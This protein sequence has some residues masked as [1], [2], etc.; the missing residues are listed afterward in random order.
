MNSPLSRLLVE[1]NC[2]TQDELYRALS[3][4]RDGERVMDTLIRSGAVEEY[5]ILNAISARSG[6]PLLPQQLP[7]AEK[8]AVGS[9]PR[10][11][12]EKYRVLPL[13]VSDG[14]MKLAVC[15]PSDVYA[16][17]DIRQI[18]GMQLELSLCESRYILRGIDYYYSDIEAISAV[19]SAES[20]ADMSDSGEAPAVKLIDSLISRGYSAGASDI[21]IEPFEKETQLRMRIDGMMVDYSTVTS[22]MHPML[23]A[24][25]KIM[26][27][28][29]I[30]EHRLPQDGNINADI[31]GR[32]ISMRVSVIPTVYG[33][34]VVLRYLNTDV[35]VDHEEMCGMDEHSYKILSEMLKAPNGLIYFT[36]PTGSGKTTTL[37]MILERMA[38]RPVNICTIE[39]PV[40]RRIPRVIQTAVNYAAG[41]DFT[42]GLKAILRQDPDIIMLG[43][44]RDRETA[45]ISVR[46]AITG[47]LV[48]STLHTNDAV[49]AV[50]RLRDMGVEPY[51][52]A[53]SLVGVVAQRLL[54]KICT[55]CSEECEPTA[56]E[57]D[58]IGRGPRYIRRGKGCHLCNYTGY[59]GRIA[60]HEVLRVDRTL[61]RMISDC[62][63]TD[64]MYSYACKEL[65]L[66]PLRVTASALVA[67]GLTTP[68]EVLRAAYFAD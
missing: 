42:T 34:K 62:K 23:I 14:V 38:E 46:A 57:R 6:Y 67:D 18:S 25:V 43:E 21:H 59:K 27:D 22:T 47:H 35:S 54:R 33:E 16:L 1:Y 65:G 12:L 64:E 44:T 17:E 40:E 9:L 19:K 41:M 31:N 36:G 66:V 3:Q 68:E 20:S 5:V 24:R 26:S 63:E 10:A 49:S 13:S 45:E 55:N 32:R 8:D 58:I 2:I 51:L 56:E 60:I 61:K 7:H 48:L 50:L 29:D 53:N 4:R 15:D 37:Y 52:T 39:D 28:L 11:V 30:A